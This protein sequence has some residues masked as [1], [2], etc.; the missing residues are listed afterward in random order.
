MNASALSGAARM[1]FSSGASAGAVSGN[2]SIFGAGVGSVSPI[3]DT[4][5]SDV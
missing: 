2:F 4:G 5:A 1:I 3:F